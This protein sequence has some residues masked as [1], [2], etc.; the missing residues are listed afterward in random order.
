MGAGLARVPQRA[1]HSPRP[2]LP[3]QPTCLAILVGFEL[4]NLICAN[5]DELGNTGLGKTL[6]G[7]QPAVKDPNTGKVIHVYANASRPV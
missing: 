3:K 5:A 7:R 4:P 1:P 6:Q 2:T